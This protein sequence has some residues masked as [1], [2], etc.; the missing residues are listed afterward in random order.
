MDYDDFIDR[1]MLSQVV[2]NLIYKHTSRDRETEK[3]SFFSII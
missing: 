3:A 1:L 2:R